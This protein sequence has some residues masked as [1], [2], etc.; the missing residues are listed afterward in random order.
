MSWFRSLE[1]WL[2]LLHWT[3]TKKKLNLWF[4]LNVAFST[5][6]LLKLGEAVVRCSMRFSN[7]HKQPSC[8]HILNRV[9]NQ[10]QWSSVIIT[11]TDLTFIVSDLWWG[12]WR[13]TSKRK[14]KTYH[15]VEG[16]PFQFKHWLLPI[17][18]VKGAF[19]CRKSV[20]HSWLEPPSSLLLCDRRNSDNHMW[21]LAAM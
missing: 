3:I 9:M 2:I 12:S 11:N 7:I 6:L 16:D 8:R 19:Y 1:M 5:L 13:K 4:G 14:R 17:S 15:R 18:A 20:S 21:H 10:K